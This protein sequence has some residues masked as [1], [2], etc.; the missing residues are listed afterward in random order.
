[1]PEQD[2]LTAPQRL[3]VWAVAGVPVTMTPEQCRDIAHLIEH[4]ER[5]LEL[6]DKLMGKAYGNV[7]VALKDAEKELE[8]HARLKLTALAAFACIIGLSVAL[9]GG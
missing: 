4:L 8:A 6:H 3:R 2:T 9:I 5:K 7:L 1:V